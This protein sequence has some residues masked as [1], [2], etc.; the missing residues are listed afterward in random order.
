MVSGN[1]DPRSSMTLRKSFSE[2]GAGHKQ[3]DTVYTL[4]TEGK[5]NA[6]LNNEES[7]SHYPSELVEP[8]T[9]EERIIAVDDFIAFVGENGKRLK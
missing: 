7:V 6:I 3:D 8:G 2:H 9:S 4:A 1:E 5:V